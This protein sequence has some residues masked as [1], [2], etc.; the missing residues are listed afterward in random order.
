MT[1]A[2]LWRTLLRWF[3]WTIGQRVCPVR[4]VQVFSLWWLQFMGMILHLWWCRMVSSRLDWFLTTGLWPWL[5][6]AC[7]LRGLVKYFHEMC[8]SDGL[9]S[10][11]L[12]TICTPFR[13][14]TPSGLPSNGGVAAVFRSGQVRP[15]CLIIS[16]SFSHSHFHL[17]LQIMLKSSAKSIFWGLISEW[18]PCVELATRKH[19][20]GRR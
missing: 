12:A 9:P 18:Q 8:S 16:Q 15:G 17:L 14:C 11:L 13:Y 20:L 3:H 5:P 6:P 19:Q 10:Y 2:L 7:F 1:G 4:K